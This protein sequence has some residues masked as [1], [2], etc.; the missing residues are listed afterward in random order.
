M[1]LKNSTFN[2]ITQAKRHKLRISFL[3]VGDSF[4]YVAVCVQLRDKKKAGN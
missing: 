1:G 4:K 3:Y 2:E